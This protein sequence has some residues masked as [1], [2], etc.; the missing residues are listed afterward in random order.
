MIAVNAAGAEPY[1]AEMN[2]IDMLGLNN[3]DIAK[4]K[5]SYDNS[6]I[7]KKIFRPKKLLS[8]KGRKE[9]MEDIADRYPMWQVMPGHSKGDG[10]YVLSKKPDYIV[11][12]PAEGSDTP[13][14]LGDRELLY[15]ADFKENYSFNEIVIPV[16]DPF[17]RF[18][19]SSKDGH[20]NFKYYKRKT[21]AKQE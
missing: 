18:Y 16:N 21:A 10:K 2:T 6:F 9:I 19:F 3:Y 5:T 1:F 15:S 20:I 11:I 4:R 7:L 8:S 13:W 14:F 17:Y 12:G